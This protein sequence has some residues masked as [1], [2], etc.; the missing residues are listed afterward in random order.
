MT[1]KSIKDIHFIKY[2]ELLPVVLEAVIDSRFKY[3]KEME[4]ENVRYASKILEEE[5]KPSVKKLKE[6]L[7][8]IA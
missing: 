7:E 1:E 4:Y 5:Y 3:L 2:S 6:I 8:I